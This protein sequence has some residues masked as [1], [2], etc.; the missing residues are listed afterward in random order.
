MISSD[1][2]PRA[3]VRPFGLIGGRYEVDASGM[4]KYRLACFIAIVVVVMIALRGFGLPLWLWLSI[5][6]VGFAST[7]ALC[8]DVVRKGR[9]L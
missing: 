6:G 2:T 7:L 9:K 8:L 5:L 4:R 1:P 3:I